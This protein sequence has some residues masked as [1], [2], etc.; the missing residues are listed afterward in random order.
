MSAPLPK[1][2]VIFK[3]VP[4][5]NPTVRIPVRGA[6][7][8]LAVSVA[9]LSMPASAASLF[10]FKGPTKAPNERVCLSFARDQAGRHNLQNIKHDNLGVGGTRDNFFAVMTCVGTVIVVMVSGDTGTDGTPLAK[11]LFEAVQREQCID[12]C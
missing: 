1:T 12:G 11:E 8:G 6:L 9:A 10:Y 3:E 7:L 5:S 2:N 4:M